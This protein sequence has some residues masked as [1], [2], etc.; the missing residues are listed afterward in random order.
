MRNPSLHLLNTH[1]IIV[2]CW[3]NLLSCGIYTVTVRKTQV[4]H[5]HISIDCTLYMYMYV[6]IPEPPEPPE[7]SELFEA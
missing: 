4:H 2:V 3:H 1:G 6:Y 7:L 5:L